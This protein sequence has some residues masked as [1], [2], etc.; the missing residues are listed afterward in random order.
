MFLRLSRI[1]VTLVGLE[2]A[3]RS[4]NSIK[5]VTPRAEAPTT[6]YATMHMRERD[7]QSVASCLAT[8]H[9][10]LPLCHIISSSC[11][12]AVVSAILGIPLLGV[13]ILS[14]LLL[15]VVISKSTKISTLRK[16]QRNDYFTQCST[17]ACWY[18]FNSL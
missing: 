5:M 8:N 14:M 17:V 10:L 2:T 15:F 18:V 1:V 6:A 16:E 3:P 7:L 11:A 9:N 13:N 12:F 4:T